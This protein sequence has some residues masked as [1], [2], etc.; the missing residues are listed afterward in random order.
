MAA[1]EDGAEAA[2][3]IPPIQSHPLKVCALAV[4]GSAPC[5][6]DVAHPLNRSIVGNLQST[7]ISKLAQMGE[8]VQ[9]IQE[10]Q[11]HK[12][13]EELSIRSHTGHWDIFQINPR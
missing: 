7:C 4:C 11:Q 6:T 13:P 12:P 2:T 10:R 8:S 9:P 3:W 1:C 5:P